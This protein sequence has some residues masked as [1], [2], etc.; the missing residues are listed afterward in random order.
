MHAL[1]KTAVLSVAVAAATLTTIVPASAGDRYFRR[2]HHHGRDAAILGAA[3]LATGLIVGSALASQPR[4]Y[5]E[6][7]VYVDPGYAPGPR[8]IDPPPPRYVVEEP[9]Y[10][11][12]VR[13]LRPR[14]AMATLERRWQRQCPVSKPDLTLLW[15]EGADALLQGPGNPALD[16]LHQHP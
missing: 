9:V 14:K 4:Y 5:D 13:E 6:G 11:P 10:A 3:G 12:P 2:H 16:F 7:P 8:Y 15:S 1:I